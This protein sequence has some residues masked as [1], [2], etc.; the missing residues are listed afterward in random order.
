[1]SVNTAATRSVTL[2]IGLVAA[3][4]LPASANAASPEVSASTRSRSEANAGR[5]GEPEVR[6]Y[7]RVITE[8]TDIY[9]GAGFSYRVIARVAKDDVLELVERGKRGGWTRVR[10]DTGITGWVLS[11]QVVIFSQANEAG[12]A[13]PFRRAGRKIRAAILGPPNL[14]TARAGGALSAGVLDGEGLFLVRPSVHVTPNVAVEAYVGPSAGHEVTRG[15]FGLAGNIYL[16][17]KIPFTFFMSLGTGAVFTRGKAD[18]LRQ[19]DWSYLLSPGGGAFLILKKGV[20]LR[21]DFR[22]HILFRAPAAQSKQEFS[23]A[24]AF[25][26]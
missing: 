7:V 14:M 19:A 6:P 2:G 20:T 21:F 22:N 10:L 12:E 3:L 15:I 16:M 1:M 18:V 4:A 11:E 5:S 8:T 26:F 23:G 9:S 24:L 25:H 17:P 13:G